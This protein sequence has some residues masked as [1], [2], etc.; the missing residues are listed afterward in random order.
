MTR[1]RFPPTGPDLV[2]KR[3]AVEAAPIDRYDQRRY[4]TGMLAPLAA[5]HD[6]IEPGSSRS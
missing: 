4:V 3:A 5:V 6:T 1:Y 2:A